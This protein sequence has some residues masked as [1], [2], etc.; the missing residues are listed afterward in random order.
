M[1]GQN[2]HSWTT[3]AKIMKMLATPRR[4]YRTSG[5]EVESAS[6]SARIDINDSK[7]HIIRAESGVSIWVGIVK[8]IDL[9]LR[10]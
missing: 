4:T 9:L 10:F 6:I 8:I 2:S 1:I 7:S 3:T 5:R